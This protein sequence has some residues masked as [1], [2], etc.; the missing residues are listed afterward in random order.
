MICLNWIL[1][2]ASLRNC[3][4]SEHVAQA[5]SQGSR[6]IGRRCYENESRLD[7]PVE[8]RADQIP[9]FCVSKCT[10]PIYRY[11]SVPLRCACCLPIHLFI[12]WTSINRT[13]C[14]WRAIPTYLEISVV[15]I[16]LFH[17]CPCWHSNSV[18]L[19]AGMLLNIATE[20]ERHQRW[21]RDVSS[22]IMFSKWYAHV[23][24]YIPS[25]DTTRM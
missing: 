7:S 6:G 13:H 3:W 24:L 4:R 9:G 11:V 8:P 21:Q 19:V 16:G 14:G 5:S 12:W 22:P 1:L 17:V 25:A 10:F 18:R 23:T 20:L 15:W 2:V